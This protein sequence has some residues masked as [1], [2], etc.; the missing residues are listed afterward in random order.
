MLFLQ[1]QTIILILL[2]VAYTI[3]VHT[4]Y[5]SL[6]INKRTTNNSKIDA[7]DDEITNANDKKKIITDRKSEIQ[8]EINELTTYLNSIKDDINNN[9][10]P[11]NNFTNTEAAVAAV[12]AVDAV[13]AVPA[14]TVA[15]G[16]NENNEIK[17]N[18]LKLIKKLNDT[19]AKILKLE[20]ELTV[21]IPKLERE[22]DLIISKA[23]TAKLKAG[24]F[25]EDNKKYEADGKEREWNDN[26]VNSREREN[27]T[28]LDKLDGRKLQEKSVVLVIMSVL[29]LLLDMNGLLT[30]SKVGDP[31]QVVV[32][33]MLVVF[34]SNVLVKFNTKNADTVTQ[35]GTLDMLNKS[36][37]NNITD[38]TKTASIVGTIPG[39]LCIIIGVQVLLK[40]VIKKEFKFKKRNFKSLKRKNKNKNKLK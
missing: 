30:S 36:N 23:E 40:S 14:A 2:S 18:K 5:D 8:K 7:A 20:E 11:G 34:G 4:S 31:L 26:N 35:M 3:L 6:D 9:V 29:V 25:D 38:K 17:K 33:I 32:G 24:P 1:I 22:A 28:I 19:N 12:A 27:K 21:T 16:N 15:A 39:V 10:N 13:D 37:K